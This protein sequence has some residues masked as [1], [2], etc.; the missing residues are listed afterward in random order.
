MSYDIQIPDPGGHS[1]Q[2]L[3]RRDFMRRLGAGLVSAMLMGMGAQPVLAAGGT[4]GLANW[5]ASTFTGQLGKPFIVNQG[6]TGHVT[7]SLHQVK[8]GV[9]KIYHN[10]KKIINAPADESFILVFRGPANSALTSKTYPFQH[11]LLGAFS[12]FV[13]PGK[14]DSSGRTYTAVVN[15]VRP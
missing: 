15:H 14:A 11:S 2:T 9:S 7:L 1:P 12:L 10:P 8:P 5:N 3:S 13:V 4:S 6:S